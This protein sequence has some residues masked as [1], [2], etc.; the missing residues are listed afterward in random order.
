[1]FD[2]QIQESLTSSNY[3]ARIDIAKSDTST[4]QSI[5]FL[6]SKGFGVY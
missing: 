2:P 1:M 5:H 4:I 6:G 3:G